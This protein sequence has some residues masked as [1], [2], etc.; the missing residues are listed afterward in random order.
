MWNWTKY[1]EL[2]FAMHV[3]PL[4]ERYCTK[5]TISLAN[6]TCDTLEEMGQLFKGVCAP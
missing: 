4:E 3:H 2:G 1:P 6:V 5:S